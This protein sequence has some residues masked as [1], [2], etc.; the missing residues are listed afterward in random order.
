MPSIGQNL[1]S[2]QMSEKFSSMTKNTKQITIEFFFSTDLTLISTYASVFFRNLLSCNFFFCF[3]LITFSNL[4]ITTVHYFTIWILHFLRMRP[5]KPRSCV[6]GSTSW[7][8]SHLLKYPKC[9]A[10]I[11]FLQPFTSYG[12][13]PQQSNNRTINN[14]QE[15][16]YFDVPTQFIHRL[17]SLV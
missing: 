4:S 12:D 7:W 2:F 10:Q 6:T 8:R 5:Y 3:L 15:M 14:E 13:F 16:A 17:S 9:R 11:S 1:Q